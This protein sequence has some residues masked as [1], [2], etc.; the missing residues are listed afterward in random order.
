MTQNNDAQTWE[1]WLARIR[2]VV[3]EHAFRSKRL[4]AEECKWIMSARI[5][6]SAGTAVFGAT[7]HK[8][9]LLV[10]GRKVPVLSIEA[11]VQCDGPQL[12]ST[13][14]HEAGHILAAYRADGQLQGHN[15]KWQEACQALGYVRPSTFA[16]PEDWQSFT[17]E[18]AS[19]L[20]AVP[21]PAS[22]GRTANAWV[23]SQ[24]PDDP[25]GTVIV[26]GPDGFVYTRRFRCSDGDGTLGGKSRGAG[27]GSRYLL[28]SC[29]HAS[30]GAQ[31]R[32]TAK[33]AQHRLTC[34][35]TEAAPHDPLPLLI[36]AGSLPASRQPSPP[37]DQPTSGKPSRHNRAS[38]SGSSVIT[39]DTG[40]PSDI[41]FPLN[42]TLPQWPTDQPL[43]RHLALVPYSA[44]LPATLPGVSG[45]TRRRPQKTREREGVTAFQY[46]LGKRWMPVYAVRRREGWFCVVKPK[47]GTVY[48]NHPEATKAFAVLCCAG[49]V[50][51]DPQHWRK[52]PSR[53][54]SK[55]AKRAA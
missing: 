48:L 38:R 24:A 17:P 19:L 49:W 42:V 44:Q 29:N 20:Q 4:T 13:L 43:P 41:Q 23:W 16:K 32:L 6:Y 52:V 51:R 30:C 2:R 18:L 50:K 12:C 39:P 25:P 5:V 54:R 40:K 37:A 15:A 8:S 28:A 36:D 53:S 1:E 10:D 11:L 34:S 26:T 31:V 21:L 55:P 46:K 22:D 7:H 33:W 27:S 35:G 45:R 9:W 47:T 3:L 14:I